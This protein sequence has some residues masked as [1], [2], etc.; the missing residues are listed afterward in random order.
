MSSFVGRQRERE[1]IADAVKRSRVVSVVGPGG[2]GKSRLA[3]IVSGDLAERFPG[4]VWHVDLVPVTDAAAL[5]QATAGAC[6]L[7]DEPGR[8]AEEAL[9]RGLS[10]MS[11]LL[12]LDNCE[13]LVAAVA[14]LVERL[15]STC[16]AL[17]VLI[18]SRARLAR[19][20][21][22]VY[23]LGGMSLDGEAS[24]LLVERAT[25]A[26]WNDLGEAQLAR[27]A[28]ICRALDGLP[29]A[30]ELAAVRLP[31]LGL[32][33]VE[34]GLADHST[35]LTG[36]PRM[37]PRQRSMYD[38]IEWSYRLLEPLEQVVLRR[39][40]VFPAG[41]DTEAAGAVVS[42]GAADADQVRRSLERLA[43]HSLLIAISGG[44]DRRWREL[45]PI[46]QF[47][48]AQMSDE[49]RWAFSSHLQW[50]HK[51]VD[52][53]LTASL[54]SGRGWQD[55][56]EDVVDD[57]RTALGW[58]A[59][60][61]SRRAAACEL[62]RNLA[63]VLFRA[64]RAR[65]AQRRY[66]QAAEL[67]AAPAAAVAQFAAAAAVAK[68]RV[69]GE[70]ALR[71][72]L[73][74][75]ESARACRDPAALAPMLARAA[76]T[77]VRFEGMFAGPAPVSTATALLDELR[78]L[79]PDDPLMYTSAALVEDSRADPTD[80]Q[81][82]ADAEHAAEVAHRLGDLLRESAALDVLTGTHIVSGRL[83]DAARCART[84]VNLL[85]GRPADPPG[86][87]E[88]KDALHMGVL[89]C[90]GAG[91]LVSA[92]RF[93]EQHRT[94]AFL[95]EQRDLAL[96]PTLLPDALA[97][98]WNEVT[99]RGQMFL[100]DWIAAGRPAAPGRSIGPC[101]VAMVHGLL[102]RPD[103]R[104]IW[105]E[106]VAQLRGVDRPSATA[107]TGYGE[108]FDAIVLLDRDRPRQAV[109]LLADETRGQSGWYGPLLS[110][111]RAA[112]LAES[113]VLAGDP[114]AALRCA[115]A[116]QAAAGNPVAAVLARRATALAAGDDDALVELAGRL[117]DLD[118][119]YQAARTLVLAGGP[120]RLRGEQLLHRLR[121]VTVPTSHMT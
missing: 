80:A 100:D 49:D 111:W 33:G 44:R 73:A 95:R 121:D 7:A 64:G 46:R 36:G 62:A 14:V 6:G 40:S 94:L 43:D 8:D 71:L 82:L 87:L 27:I 2:V 25:F 38:T 1:E 72:D 70:E 99:T 41:F 93:G 96:E 15:V 28:G 63:T 119:P 114:L 19:S 18:T 11:A 20:F 32:G 48:L 39:V 50:A 81:C 59:L 89:A 74:A 113:A 90:V 35:L 110:Q 54:G 69:L 37:N 9:V 117:D 51:Q 106:V 79:N 61:P 29:L 75:V 65:E 103:E 84:R 4:G 83:T 58:A 22:L 118:V 112:L 16:A 91:D 5:V 120:H 102:G 66:E 53:L 104:E 21:E 23:S 105:L 116:E 101:A 97:G 56:F 92:S 107:S 60:Q 55:D 109:Q 31:S 34:R 115:Q 57:A 78:T 68:C 86:A 108:L 47:G 3:T 13:H 98:R 10:N 88:L 67:A 12:V 42:F 77:I 76:E 24:D 85:D 26:G 30:I 17:H 45:E 52:A